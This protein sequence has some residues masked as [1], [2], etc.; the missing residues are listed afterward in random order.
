M[1]IQVR[2]KRSLGITLVLASVAVMLDSFVV[3]IQGEFPFSL[4]S[5]LITLFGGVLFLKNKY[6]TISK[7][8]I[9]L[10][11]LV[12]KIDRTYSLKFH[13]NVKI[14]NNRLYVK[15]KGNFEKVPVYKWLI[16]ERDWETLVEQ[17]DRQK[18]T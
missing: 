10:Y 17:C 3:G 9:V 16:D 12:G 8:D 4:L 7:H 2:Y 14:E 11:T 13:K 6:F 18:S 1:E 15:E 5:G